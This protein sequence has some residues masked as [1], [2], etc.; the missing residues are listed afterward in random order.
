MSANRGP[1]QKLVGFCLGAKDRLAIS[2]DWLFTARAEEPRASVDR[3]HD[4]ALCTSCACAALSAERELR[5]RAVSALCSTAHSQLI[6]AILHATC[7]AHVS[8]HLGAV[9]P[10]LAAPGR[11]HAQPPRGPHMQCK[12]QE[13]MSQRLDCI[14]K[15]VL[16]VARAISVAAQRSSPMRAR[17]Q[18]TERAL[19]PVRAS[20]RDHTFETWTLNDIMYVHRAVPPEAWFCAARWATWHQWAGLGLQCGCC[21]VS[22]DGA[23]ATASTRF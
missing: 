13:P 23:S 15:H 2:A 5:A 12:H 4:F 8:R 18:R 22:T 9:A 14:W 11:E 1:P 3:A 17:A 6:R 19:Q 20:K 7:A 21:W 16:A 10:R